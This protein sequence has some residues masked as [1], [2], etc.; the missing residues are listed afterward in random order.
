[1]VHCMRIINPVLA[2]ISE[3]LCRGGDKPRPYDHGATIPDNSGVL[4][5][6]RDAGPHRVTGGCNPDSD[7]VIKKSTI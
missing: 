3:N 2:I 5:Q 1:M 7:T 6:F 4:R